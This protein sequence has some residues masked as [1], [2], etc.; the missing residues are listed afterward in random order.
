MNSTDRPLRTPWTEHQDPVQSAVQYVLQWVVYIYPECEPELDAALKQVI[1]YADR[2][3]QQHWLDFID[4]QPLDAHL[5]ALN[6]A[7]DQLKKDQVPY[8][9]KACWHLILKRHP[10]PAL[11]PS[12]LRILAQIFKLNDKI[13]TDIGRQTQSEVDRPEHAENKPLRSPQQDYLYYMEDRLLEQANKLPG[14]TKPSTMPSLLFGFVVGALAGTLATFMY[15][16]PADNQAADLMI[17]QPAEP[18]ADVIAEP[19]TSDVEADPTLANTKDTVQA[20]A[21]NAATKEEAE[22]G[23]STESTGTS[24]STASGTAEPLPEPQ[25]ESPAPAEPTTEQSSAQVSSETVDPVTDDLVVDEDVRLMQVTASLLNLR[26]TP[27][28]SGRVIARLGRG[29]Q[30]FL[31]SVSDDG[32]WSQVRVQGETGYVGSA[33]LQ[34]I[35]AS[36][37]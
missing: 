4:Q 29:A 28:S 15:L 23:V 2:E 19:V 12:A 30:V 22:P 24:D 14:Q 10:Y 7:A 13:I 36:G 1:P 21:G 35:P 37:Q 26:A 6:W 18:L 27:S 32:F 8:L 17:N 5:V 25:R 9:I 34:P 3:I 11:I 20:V 33:F 31:I 16:A